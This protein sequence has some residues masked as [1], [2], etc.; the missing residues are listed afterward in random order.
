MT[1]RMDHFLI[2]VVNNGFVKNSFINSS[3]QKVIKA[4]I[5]SF[6]NQT[7]KMCANAVTALR[8]SERF[9]SCSMGKINVWYSGPGASN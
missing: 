4:K 5:L 1:I 2:T 8:L 6:C 7:P 9:W 3:Y